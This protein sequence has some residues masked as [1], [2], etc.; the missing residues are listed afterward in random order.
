MS[1]HQMKNLL[2]DLETLGTNSSAVILQIAGVV[3]SP[4]LTVQ[5]MLDNRFNIKLDVK[6]QKAAGRTVEKGTLDFW[7]KQPLAVRQQVLPPSPNDVSMCE[8]IRQFEDKLKEQDFDPE[9]NFDELIF[10]RGTKDVDWLSNMWIQNGYPTTLIPWYKVFD[11]RTAFNVLGHSPK[12][13]GYP[14][15]YDFDNRELKKQLDELD[16]VEFAHNAMHDVGREIIMLRHFG[17]I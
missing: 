1:S 4:D 9:H 5:Q 17:L 14:D 6:E 8:A 10:Q 3:M 16:S 2:V 7:A 13:N 11:I 15:L 12:L